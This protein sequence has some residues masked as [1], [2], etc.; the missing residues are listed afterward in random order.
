MVERLTQGPTSVTEL[1][2]PLSISLVAV[3]QHAHVLET[4]GLVRTK[5]VGRV[6]ICSIDTAALRSLESWITDRRTL[7]ERHL[8]RLGQYL[9]DT[10]Y[11]QHPNPRTP[12]ER[13]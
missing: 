11:V 9:E 13:P 2:K 12:K 7:A 6:R 1:A 4:S 8:D 3:V 5:K 10:A